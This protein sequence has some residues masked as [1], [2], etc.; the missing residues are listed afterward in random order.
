[1]TFGFVGLGVMGQPMALNMARAGVPLL[2]WNRT[3]VRAEALVAAGADVARNVADVFARTST[4]LLMMANGEVLDATLGRGT[5]RFE[6]LVRDHLVVPLGT[7]SPE[8]SAGLAAD[9]VAAGGRYV[10]APVSGSRVRPRTRRSSACSPDRLRTST[11]SGRCWK[12]PAG[13]R[14]TA[15]PCLGRSA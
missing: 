1:M 2:V 4:V 9:V 3:P 15:A 5:P 12:P 14:S 8:Y 6:A 10:E 7:T 13:R 11:S